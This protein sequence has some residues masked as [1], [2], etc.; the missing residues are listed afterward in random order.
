MTNQYATLQ[1]TLRQSQSAPKEQYLR[2]AQSCDGK[3]PQEF[4]TWLDML[5]ADLFL[6][7]VHSERN[8]LFI[9]WLDKVSQLATICNKNP[10]EVAL[11]ISRG[12][13]HKYIRE[14]VSSGLS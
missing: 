1:E 2:N 12:N 4:R 10:M 13:L 9:S 3:N 6:A 5:G 14:L 8:Y 7:K 11:A